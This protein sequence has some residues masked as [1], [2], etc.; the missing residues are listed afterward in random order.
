MY[1]N[2]TVSIH[3]TVCYSPH[4]QTVEEDVEG[5][6]SVVEGLGREARRLVRADHFDSTNITARQVCAFYEN[7]V[8]L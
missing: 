7:N 8:W 4:A 2:T 5:Y 1:L 6:V 3:A